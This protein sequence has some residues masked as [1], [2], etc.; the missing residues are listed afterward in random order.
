VISRDKA[1]LPPVYN[2]GAEDVRGRVTKD[3]E[4]EIVEPAIVDVTDEK[5]RETGRLTNEDGSIVDVRELRPST[6]GSTT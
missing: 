4:S 6:F 2:K 3:F 1:E 5:D